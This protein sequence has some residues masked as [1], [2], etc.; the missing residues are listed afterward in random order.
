MNRSRKSLVFQRVSGIRLLCVIKLV[1][2]ALF[3][4]HYAAD[5]EI[6][7]TEHGIRKEMM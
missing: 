6:S 3:Y 1:L 7:Y 2:L 5:Y 4:A